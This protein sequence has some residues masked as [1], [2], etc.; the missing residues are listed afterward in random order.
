[1][2]GLLAVGIEGRI[3]TVGPDLI[4]RGSGMTVRVGV[5]VGLFC[6]W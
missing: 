1:M 4:V 5:G 6:F 3:L 2:R